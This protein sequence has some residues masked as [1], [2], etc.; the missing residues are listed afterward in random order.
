MSKLRK[1]LTT[2]YSIPLGLIALL[3][4]GSYFSINK[5]I[6]EQQ[7]D[8]QV[9]NIAGRQ[10]VLIQKTAKATLSLTDPNRQEYWTRH[11]KELKDASDLFWKSYQNLRGEDQ[12]MGFISMHSPKIDSLHETIFPYARTLKKSAGLLLQEFN[13]SPGTDATSAVAQESAESILQQEDILLNLSNELARAYEA[14]DRG[15]VEWLGKA[16]LLILLAGIGVIIFSI[17]G[18]F[19]PMVDKVVSDRNHIIQTNEDLQTSEEELR[20]QQEEMAAQRE[21]VEQSNKR[22]KENEELLKKY[23]ERLK[24]KEQEMTEKNEELQTS[25]EKLRKQQEEI[26]AQREAVEEK[27]RELEEKNAFIELSIRSAEQIQSSILPEQE[28]RKQILPEHCL[29]Y[30]PKDVVSG[31]FYWLSQHGDKTLIGVIDCTGHGISGAFI[32]LLGYSILR[33]VIYQQACYQPEQVLL[34]LNRGISEYLRQDENNSNY[35]MDAGFCL[36]DRSDELSPKL[37]FAGAKNRIFYTNNGE[38]DIVN[39]DRCSLGGFYTKR[40]NNFNEHTLQL[41]AG[42]TVY[43]ATDGYVDQANPERKKF[44]KKGFMKLLNELQREPIYAQENQ[45][46]DAFHE[47]RGDFP[48]RDDVT[49]LGFRV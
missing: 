37:T 7:Y 33:Q 19:R 35:G 36:L 38:I 47:H 44:G 5:L 28:V 48:Q 12:T 14:E 40:A 2:Q 30:L 41:Q 3:L 46:M 10:R 15:H 18:V 27:S 21:A 6:D 9:I 45:L 49:V 4:L 39:G 8:D 34:G 23:I 26:V 20:Q 42:D 16:R 1:R 17:F 32:S 13:S 22:L 11:K 24:V 29:F 25:E 43:M 31:D